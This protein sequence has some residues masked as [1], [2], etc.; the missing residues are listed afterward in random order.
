MPFSHNSSSL[1]YFSVD[2][3][4]KLYSVKRRKKISINDLLFILIAT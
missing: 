3:I 4:A 2:L 1:S